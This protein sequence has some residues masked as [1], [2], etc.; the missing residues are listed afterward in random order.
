MESELMLSFFDA[1]EIAHVV[2]YPRRDSQPDPETAVYPVEVDDGIVIV[3]R[4]Y[5]GGQQAPTILY[6]HGNGETA[7]DYDIISS[8]YTSRGINLFVA[9][10]RGYGLS[11]GTPAFRHM[12]ADVHPLFRRLKE[13]LRAGGYSDAVFVMGRSLGSGPAIEVAAHYESELQGLIIE[14]GFCDAFRLLSYIGLPLESPPQYRGGFPNGVKMGAIHLPTLVIHAAEDHLIP[15]REAEE[16]VQR[17]V[18]A[19]KRLVVIPG[20]D[21]NNLMMIGRERYFQEIQQFVQDHV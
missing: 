10:Y 17:C 11:T 19:E 15:L 3:C 20:A 14:S 16:L 8:L 5:A 4:F 21:H 13:I 1:P 7:G 12:L 6:F 9:D 18:A 2:F